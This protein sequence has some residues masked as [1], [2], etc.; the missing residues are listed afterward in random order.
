MARILIL[1]D[2]ISL[3]SYWR[4]LLE[5]HG[6]QVVCCSTAPKALEEASSTDFDL[7]VADMM[8]KEQNRYANSGGLTLLS[9]RVTGDLP[10]IPIIGVSGH[11]PQAKLLPMSALEIAKTM[12]VD[13]A[14][15]KPIAPDTLLGAIDK[16]LN[17]AKDS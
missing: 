3:S 2:E 12:G 4:R 8:L 5:E 11:K 14:L 9:K 10:P 1:E 16:L 13:L 17:K 15:Y 6:H 7:I